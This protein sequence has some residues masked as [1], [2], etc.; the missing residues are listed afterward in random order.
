VIAPIILAVAM[1]MAPAASG[2]IVFDSYD[3]DL[4]A[5]SP[6]GGAPHPFARTHAREIDPAWSPDGRRLAFLVDQA[7]GLDDVFVADADG[8]GRRRLTTASKAIAGGISWSADGTKIV[9]ADLA[10]R[11][12]TVSPAGGKPR[13]IRAV[14]PL[15]SPSWSPDGS[16]LAAV[17]GGDL[18]LL[19]AAGGAERVLAH[20]A[21]QPHWA[22][23]GRS[24]VFTGRTRDLYS[25]A[26]TGG[27]TT[28]LTQ[29]GNVSGSGWAPDGSA[30][31]FIVGSSQLW[32]MHPDGSGQ[33]RL[34]NRG[35][36]LANVAWRP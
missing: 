27:A 1:A 33:R 8:G 7:D 25:I 29:R 35:R 23:D 12:N 28:R 14:G 17:H 36:P 3:S 20:D 10:G 31:A 22:P 16:K 18:V 9:F 13:R 19:A 26:P 4:M 6:A 30:I 32:A 34:A 24:I 15:I 2:E 11:L 5:V 21:G